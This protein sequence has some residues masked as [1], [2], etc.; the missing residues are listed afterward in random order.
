MVH[1]GPY[2]ATSDGRSTSVGTL[3]IERF[4]RHVAWQSCPDAL[5]P[6]RAAGIRIRSA[7][8]DSS[9]A[10]WRV[11]RHRT[12]H[13]MTLDK[14]PHRHRVSL[15]GLPA[16]RKAFGSAARGCPRRWR[17]KASPGRMS[18]AS[19]AARSSTSANGILTVSEL[20]AVDDPVAAMRSAPRR[21]LGAVDKLLSN[22]LFHQ[23]R[24]RPSNREHA[25]LPQPVRSR[26]G[27]S[28]RRDV[29]PQLAR[30]RDRRADPRRP[31]QGRLAPRADSRNARRQ[32]QGRGPRLRAGD[33]PQGPAAGRRNL[34]AIS[35][36]RH[37]PRR[38]SVHQEPTHRVGR[39]RCPESACSPTRP[40]TI[41][42]PRSCSPFRPT[43]KIHGAALGNDVN[44]RDYEGRSALLLGE[45]KDQNGSC[46]IGP[47]IRL[48]DGDFTLA[49]VEQAEVSLRIVGEDGFELLDASRMERDQ[50]L[51]GVARGPGLRGE[52][53][54]SRRLH[55][56][57]R[58]DV[59]ADQGP[60]RGG[61]GLHAPR[62]RPRRNLQPAARQAGQLGQP[63]RPDSALGLSA[64]G[65]PRFRPATRAR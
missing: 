31:Q 50:P 40:G 39:L 30:T 32:S 55:A 52:P 14:L 59:R 65:V 54:V 56:V 4:T 61:P 17:T 19:K 53:S 1:G 45:A 44:L 23:I 11:T 51:A 3:A 15:R 12:W 9:T 47:F 64:S 43:G 6:A 21:S 36:S 49:D 41:P 2:P 29:R 8:T 33:G 34:V 13:T 48:F 63:L 62:R 16:R 58:H 20:L 5:L 57:P 60:R 28:L 24:R 42:S 18:S 27:E 38:R 37:R 46:A 25:R 7:F 35:R 22:S 10:S 26:R